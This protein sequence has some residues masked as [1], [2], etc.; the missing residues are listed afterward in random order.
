AWKK[1]FD[2]QG[3][4]GLMDQPRGVRTG[5]RLPDITKRTILLLKQSHQ[6][7][8]DGL[9][10]SEKSRSLLAPPRAE[11]CR[12]TPVPEPSLPAGV[13]P[14]GTTPPHGESAPS[15]IPRRLLSPLLNCF[16]RAKIR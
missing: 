2:Q 9:R 16:R 14:L 6:T 15:N 5:S 8:V 11:S 4:A 1:Q 3:P 13:A 12:I 10:D 7:S